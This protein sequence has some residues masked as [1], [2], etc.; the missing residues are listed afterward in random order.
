[1]GLGTP[2][3]DY[4]ARGA[5]LGLTRGSGREH[6]VRAV[7]EGIAHRGADLLDAANADT[8]LDIHTVRVDGG[9]IANPTFVQALADAAD[10]PIEVAPVA[11]STTIGAAFMAGLGVGIWDDIHEL[12]DLWKPARIVEPSPGNDHAGRRARWRD[13]VD[14]AAG[15][16]PDLSA[17]DF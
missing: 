3:W 14:R 8:G 4:G 6:V 11:E 16:H 5:L 13:A 1:M 9:M 17:L 12:D 10:L 2:R 7:L 15:W